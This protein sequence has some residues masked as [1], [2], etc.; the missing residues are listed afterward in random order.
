MKLSRYCKF[1]LTELVVVVTVLVCL[2]CV[3]LP[4]LYGFLAG[5]KTERCKGNLK[6]LGIWLNV[7]LDANDNQMPAYEEGWVQPLADANGVSVTKEIPPD[8]IL[9]CPSQSSVSYDLAVGPL[10]WWRGSNYGIN[11]HLSS[12]LVSSGDPLPHWTQAKI[13]K[14]K[15]P[16]AKVAFADTVGGNY[17][18]V[19]DR[20]PAVAGIS[21]MGMTV[22]DGIPPNPSSPLPCM[23]HKDGAAVFLF[24]NGQVEARTAW[25][26]FM[27][28]R[29]TPGY[30]FWHGEHWYPGLPVTG[31]PVGTGPGGKKPGETPKVQ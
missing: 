26:Q 24:L 11:Q 25:P 18:G 20:D 15:R 13:G 7:Y 10:E 31:K 30:E 6:E 17:F 9:D 2:V 28:G 16:E 3:L 8:G 1:S 19:K 12:N 27:L 21:R 29:G 4:A 22:S 14:I 23:R 5:A